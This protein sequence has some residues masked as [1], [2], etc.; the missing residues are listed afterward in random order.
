MKKLLCC[1]LILLIC[2]AGA[3]A[4]YD[5]VRVTFEDG[6]SL[7]VPSGWVSYQ[8]C[9]E[10]RQNGYLYCL[11]SP[12]GSRLMYIQR[13]AAEYTDLEALQADLEACPNI[14]LRSA[15]V[16]ANGVEFLMYNFGDCDASGCMTFCEDSVINLLFT[17]QS[18]T[19]NMLIAASTMESFCF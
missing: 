1:I 3:E 7:S 16:N 12:D 9:E 11:G 4:L 5:T 15:S 13:W 19:E 14:T 17:P 8:V 2:T 10:N 18:D 6:F